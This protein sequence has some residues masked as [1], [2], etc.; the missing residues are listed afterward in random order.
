MRILETINDQHYSL[1][2]SG[3]YHSQTLEGRHW[4]FCTIW[5]KSPQ[6]FPSDDPSVR[7]VEHPVYTR[8]AEVVTKLSYS[9]VTS[10]PPEMLG[11]SRQEMKGKMVIKRV[12]SWLIK[13]PGTQS[14]AASL[15]LLQPG[16]FCHHFNPV[17]SYFVYVWN[18][19]KWHS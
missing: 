15:S 3:F 10:Y 17:I 16:L 8:R 4:C 2:V 19:K 12:C 18:E 5:G 13:R 14:R 9:C 6:G 7:S 11:S 1:M